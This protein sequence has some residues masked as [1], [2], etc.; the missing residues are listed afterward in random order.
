MARECLLETI[1]IHPKLGA[2]SEAV[3]ARLAA[4]TG[5]SRNHSVPPSTAIE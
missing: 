3:P 4:L 2:N 1:G 5:S